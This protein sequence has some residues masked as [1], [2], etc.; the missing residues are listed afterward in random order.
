VAAIKA[1]KV[2]CGRIVMDLP[3]RTDGLRGPQIG[4]IFEVDYATV[5]RERKRLFEKVNKDRKNMWA[6]GSIRGCLVNNKNLTRNIPENLM[7]CQEKSTL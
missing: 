7:Q 4:E 5:S 6:L 3:N 2:I 1:G